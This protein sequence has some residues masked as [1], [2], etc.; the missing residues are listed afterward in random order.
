MGILTLP[1]SVTH[2]ESALKDSWWENHNRFDLL[3]QLDRY[4]RWLV[5]KVSP[6]IRGE[7]CEVGC[8]IGNMIQF[9]LHHQRV[10]GLEPF[11]PSLEKAKELFSAHQ[12]VSF[13]GHWLADCPN[14]D[15]PPE[16][17]DT[18]V[19]MNCLEH[20]EDDVVAMSTLRQLCRRDGRVVILVPAHMCIYGGL[21]RSAG[22][23]RRYNKRSLRRVFEGGGLRV[24]DG[25]Y[26]NVFGFFGWF[27]YA[28]ILGLEQLPAKP[29]KLFNRLVPMLDTLERII[30]P[31]FG[32]SLIMVGKPE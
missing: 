25:F 2:T 11:Q 24:V 31:P 21:D 18:V 27:W 30:P 14:E 1:T 23:Y 32:Q 10:V 7:V 26:M 12:N 19:S 6:F 16:S 17:F 8:G 13:Y 4:N 9:L 28:R 20:I 29:A 15:V 22:H 5:E 3:N